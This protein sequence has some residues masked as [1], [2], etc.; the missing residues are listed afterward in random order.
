MKRCATVITDS[1]QQ[2]SYLSKYC[3]DISDFM[4]WIHNTKWWMKNR[5][6]LV[7]RTAKRYTEYTQQPYITWS[8]IYT[9]HEER[10]FLCCQRFKG[11][12]DTTSIQWNNTLTTA[13]REHQHMEW[14]DLLIQ[15]SL[16]GDPCNYLLLYSCSHNPSEGCK[17]PLNP[18]RRLAKIQPNRTFQRKVG[19]GN[20][21]QKKRGKKR[22]VS[23]DID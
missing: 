17:T 15:Y 4:Q 6:H 8:L 10:E 20:R 5:I 12:C 13:N 3:P 23:Q 18:L 2:R 7:Q 1:D 14:D 9:G 19:S 16:L 22:P 21:S 11:I